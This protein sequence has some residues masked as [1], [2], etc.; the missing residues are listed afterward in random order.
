[1]EKKNIF[2]IIIGALVGIALIVSL[3]F[4][5]YQKIDQ[6]NKAYSYDKMLKVYN[7]ITYNEKM[8]LYLFYGDGCPHCAKEDAFFESISS[9]YGDKYNLVKF[10]TWY[11]ENNK[12][13]KEYVVDKL[14]EDG[15]IVL[16][17]VNT[18]ESYHKAVPLL[19]IGN[20][21]FLGYSNQMDD[22]I[23]NAIEEQ[24]KEYDIMKKLDLK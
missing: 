12:K 6:K 14:V 1:M 21:S 4:T 2:N 17:E 15:Y 13:L 8:N 19:I 24:N 10:E 5:I 9:Q 23:I 7:S 18:L 20:K 22:A 16:D 11:N 3:G